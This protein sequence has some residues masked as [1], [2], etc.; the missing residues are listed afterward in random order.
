MP[1]VPSILTTGQLDDRG[2]QYLTRQDLF[3]LGAKVAT[4]QDAVNFYVAVCSWGVGNKARDVYRRLGAL[5]QP[6]VGQK[7]LQGILRAKDPETSPKDAYTGF[8][9]RNQYRIKGLGPAF[10]TKLLYFAAGTEVSRQQRHLILDQKV[11]KSIGWPRKIWWSPDEYRDYLDL[12]ADVLDLMLE[13]ERA[14]C[15]EKRLFSL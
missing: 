12:I 6:E 7:L 14:D 13:A 1:P 4:P 15:L 11:A 2:R 5:A 8:Y 10:Y 3:Q 9:S